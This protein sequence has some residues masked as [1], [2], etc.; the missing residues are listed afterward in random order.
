MAYKKTISDRMR[1]YVLF[2]GKEK[3]YSCRAIA[4]QEKIFKSSVSLICEEKFS[5]SKI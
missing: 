3:R 5:A 4:K 1:A 2:L